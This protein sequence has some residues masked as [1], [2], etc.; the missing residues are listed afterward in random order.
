MRVILGVII[1]VALTIGTAYFHDTSLA[2]PVN[3]PTRPPATMASGAIVNWD[4]LGSLVRE[5]TA[6]VR[7]IW[8]KA[9]GG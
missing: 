6:F 3:D 2:A 7:G 4:V 1:G 9:V 8:N 5:Q